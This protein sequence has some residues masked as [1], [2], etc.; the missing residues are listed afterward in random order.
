MMGLVAVVMRPSRPRR[1]RRR[2]A[3]AVARLVMIVDKVYL[4]R[5]DPV[6][7]VGMVVRR[8]VRMIQLR[9]RFRYH[10]AERLARSVQSRAVIRRPAP[11]RR[12]RRRR[13]GDSIVVPA[14]WTAGG[15]AVEEVCGVRSHD[16]VAGRREG[17]VQLGRS[18]DDG[19]VWRADNYRSVWR[20]RRLRGTRITLSVGYPDHD[21]G[22]MVRGRRRGGRYQAGHGNMSRGLPKAE[23]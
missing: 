2:R 7:V 11:A 19:S 16:V 20:R 3:V 5:V 23:A 21:V 13:R 18:E 9:V 8:L 22:Q 17:R 10:G 1:R 4:A 15:T 12:R 6:H 14:S